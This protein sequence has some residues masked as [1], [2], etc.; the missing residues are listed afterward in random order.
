M[1]QSDEKTWQKD[2]DKVIWEHQCKRPETCDPFGHWT[3]VHVGPKE[4][5]ER[6]REGSAAVGGLRP[7][8]FSGL[9]TFAEHFGTKVHADRRNQ[10]FDRPYRCLM[11]IYFRQL[12]LENIK[13]RECL[14]FIQPNWFK[15][16]TI[17]L[18]S[19]LKPAKLENPSK[20]KNWP[21]PLPPS[22]SNQNPIPF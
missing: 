10:S 19:F 15:E 6:L 5:R 2:N 21:L 4:G 17:W 12:H 1:D 16:R 22:S 11:M 3:L 20:P 14:D 18:L 9:N 7:S 8:V 13:L